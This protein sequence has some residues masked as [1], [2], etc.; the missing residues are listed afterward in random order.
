MEKF[1]KITKQYKNLKVSFI[2]NNIENAQITYSS[3]EILKMIKDNKQ[4]FVF[5]DLDNNKVFEFNFSTIRSFNKK[6]VLGDCYIIQEGDI[7]KVK[8]VS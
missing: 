5:E 2:F 3:Q 7:V 6:L 1:K 4:A 8:T